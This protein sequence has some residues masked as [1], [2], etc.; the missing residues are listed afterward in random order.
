[1]DRGK[2]IFGDL[3]LAFG[4]VKKKKGE[5]IFQALRR[6]GKEVRKGRRQALNKALRRK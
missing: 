6:Q 2:L 4:L 3:M 5:G 1:M